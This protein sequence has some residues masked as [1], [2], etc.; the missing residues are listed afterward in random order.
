MDFRTF[1]TPRALLWALAGVLVAVL[2]ISASTSAAAFSV[3]NPSWDGT[4]G[5]QSTATDAGLD[6]QVALST[7]TY[8]NVEPTNTVAIVISPQ[9]TYTPTDLARIQT[10]VSAGG[11]LIVADDFRG[12]NQLLRGIGVQSRFDGQL[13]RDPRNHGVTTAMPIASV[14]ATDSAVSGA[15]TIMLNHGTII[16]PETGTVLAQSSEFSYLDRDRDA[17]ID[18]NEPLESHPVAVRETLGA[19]QVILVS[20]GSLFINSMLERADNEAFTRALID[21]ASLVVI[22]TTQTPATPPLQAVFLS[23]RSNTLLQ[24]IVVLLLGAI[25]YGIPLLSD[26]HRFELPSRP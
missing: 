22:D 21:D 15:D 1:I 5:V 4:S 13:L 17:E 7:N 20:D 24:G 18:D 19:G 25:G 23:L 9:A 10:F 8:S 16:N 11:T 26:S 14:V 12:A 2:L 3:F 6:T